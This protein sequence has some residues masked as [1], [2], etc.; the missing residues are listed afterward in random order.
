MWSPYN[1]SKRLFACLF[2]LLLP[3]CGPSIRSSLAPGAP[4][5]ASLAVL[6]SEYSGEIPR[7]RLN[8]VRSAVIHELR[9]NHFVVVEDRVLSSVCSTPDCPEKSQLTKDYLV[10]GFVKLSITSFSRNNFIAGYYNQ[11]NGSIIVSDSAGQE[12][13]SV[14]HTENESG[15]VLL[16]SGQVLEGIL[17]QVKH[18]GDS[19]FDELADRFAKKVV[20]KLP[21]PNVSS[22]ASQPEGLELA[23]TSTSTVWSSP[24]SYTVCV[25]GTPHSFA[26]LVL[27][28]TRSSLR[29]LR[30]GHYCGSFSALVAE[31]FEGIQAVELRSAFGNSLRRDV[32]IPAQSPCSLENRTA[33]DGPSR[34]VVSCATIGT[35]STDQ[36]HGCSS[37]LPLCSADKLVVYQA[38]S[39][40]GPYTKVSEQRSASIQLPPDGK[41]LS[42][43]AF[44]RG[45]V[46]SQPLHVADRK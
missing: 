4:L 39:Q 23:L 18:S 19:A 12:L 30:P 37:D 32:T 29:E 36:V 26:Y 7:E 34:A 6:P 44:G 27:S 33:L 42:L 2:A 8:L 9:N 43:V 13:T 25:D 11:L 20:E 14:D 40:S 16:Q 31:P 17:S 22:R 3:G 41:S 15:G 24:S 45:G 46:A 10:D 5:P 28:L 35:N 1:G 21:S 38:P